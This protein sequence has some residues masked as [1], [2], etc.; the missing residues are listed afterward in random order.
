MNEI[1]LPKEADPSKMN[2]EELQEFMAGYPTRAEMNKYLNNLY[3]T[4]NSSF[5]MF[6]GYTVT[7][8]AITLIEVFA[9]NN[10]KISPDEF[11]KEFFEQTVKL[12]EAGKESTRNPEE[13]E[14]RITEMKNDMDQ[15]AREVDI[16]MF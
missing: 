4:I 1:D 15:K 5:G 7:A 8:L 10:I 13:L 12:A 3:G 16:S 11:V 2:E 6:Q 9:E 14:Q